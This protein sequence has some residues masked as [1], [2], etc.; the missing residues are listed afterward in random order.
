MFFYCVEPAHEKVVPKKADYYDWKFRIKKGL[1]HHIIFP[2]VDSCLGVI[3][4]L[5]GDTMFAGHINGFL[6]DDMSPKTYQ[7]AFTNLTNELKKD[8][9]ARAVVFGDTSSWKQN[10]VKFPWPIVTEI[11]SGDKV[12][13]GVDVMVSVDTGDVQAMKYLKDRDFKKAPSSADLK[14]KGKLYEIKKS[15]IV[16]L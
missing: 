10:G 5:G 6:D 3:C 14:W 1:S 12:P 15:E 7:K 16:K 9:V 13:Q 8:Q 11:Q 4:Q 2:H